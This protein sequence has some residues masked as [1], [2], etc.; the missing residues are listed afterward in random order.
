MVKKKDILKLLREIKTEDMPSIKAACLSSFLTVATREQKINLYEAYLINAERLRFERDGYKIVAWRGRVRLQNCI[1]LLNQKLLADVFKDENGSRLYKQWAFEA[2]DS[3]KDKPKHYILDNFTELL[4]LNKNAL[5]MLSKIRRE[6][7]KNSKVYD[8]CHVDYFPF[9]VISAEDVLL[10]K[11]E[12][13]IEKK[14][15][16]EVEDLIL[17]LS[18]MVD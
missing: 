6:P 2:Y 4:N 16:P 7:N 13:T 10:G 1:L 14:L 11:D 3:L 8:Y 5:E 9:E 17:Q 18:L 15:S 12:F